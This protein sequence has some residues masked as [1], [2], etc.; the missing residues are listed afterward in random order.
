MKKSKKLLS[1][2]LAATM[3]FGLNV[4]SVSA[5]PTANAGLT[6]D[7]KTAI[8]ELTVT[9]KMAL[10][11]GIAV[12][13]D[14][15]TF[16]LTPSSNGASTATETKYENK[17]KVH[18]GVVKN[19]TQGYDTTTLTINSDTAIKKE[20]GFSGVIETTTFN[21]SGMKNLFPEEGIY[22][23]TVTEVDGA[24]EKANAGQ[25]DGNSTTS[26]Y[27]TYD[28]TEFQVDFY[29]NADKDI[30]YIQ[31]QNLSLQNNKKVPITFTNTYNV[32]AITI[33]KHVTGDMGDK[34][35][36]FEFQIKI[37]A[38]GDAVQFK[39][40]DLMDAYK[41]S[42]QNRTALTGDDAI[43]VGGDK[44]DPE[45]EEGWQTFTLADGEELV[46]ENIP[47]GMIFWVRENDYSTD[48]YDTY[49]QIAQ[50]TATIVDTT[51]AYGQA[52]RKAD[53]VTTTSGNNVVS[54]KN[55]KDLPDTGISLDVV[56]YVVVVL[57][58]AAGALLLIFKRRRN[59]R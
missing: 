7:G 10:P 44:N 14:I 16:K 54:F 33:Q 39:A 15:F 11:E 47:V 6:G 52:S 3:A 40:G 42:G 4:A 36:Q 34:S 12:P 55:E 13:E 25:G 27:I 18:T 35:K 21:L 45:A 38:G 9:K 17:M 23:Y 5:A 58:A 57:I 20:D 46:L 51:A 1:M 24:S 30:V 43:R 31:A 53:Y 59:A 56:P 50:R 37:P 28:S 48:G 8:T 2:L 49:V 41:V 19:T 32:T 22:R 26:S 29:V